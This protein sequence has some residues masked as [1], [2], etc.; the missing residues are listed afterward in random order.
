VRRSLRKAEEYYPLFMR[1]IE[2]PA[3]MRALMIYYY[4]K[5]VADDQ[6]KLENLLAEQNSQKS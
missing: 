4:H 2:G 3:E 6:R 5:S 1:K